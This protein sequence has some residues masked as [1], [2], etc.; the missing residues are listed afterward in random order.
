MGSIL[1]CVEDKRNFENSRP[2][3]YKLYDPESINIHKDVHL[4]FPMHK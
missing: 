1:C 4:K 3:E 2:E